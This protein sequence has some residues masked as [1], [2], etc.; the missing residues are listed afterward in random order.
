LN[1]EPRRG[2]AWPPLT[3]LLAPS[4]IRPLAQGANSE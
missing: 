1:I 2:S 3:P 4:H